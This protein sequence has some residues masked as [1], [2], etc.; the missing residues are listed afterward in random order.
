M[1]IWDSNVNCAKI[2]QIYNFKPE[3]YVYIVNTCLDYY[4]TVDKPLPYHCDICN[5]NDIIVAEG[6]VSEL[7]KYQPNIFARK[8]IYYKKSR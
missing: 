4:V 8:K 7:K 6:Y 2:L 3:Q 1:I 5:H